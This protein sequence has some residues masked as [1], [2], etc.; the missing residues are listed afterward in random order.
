GNF[1]RTQLREVD[2]D[3]NLDGLVPNAEETHKFEEPPLRR[4]ARTFEFRELTRP[5]VYVID[6]IGSGKSSRALVRKGRLKPVVTT[7]TAGQNVAVVDEGNRPV[8]GATVWLGGKEYPC[9]GNGKAIVPFSSQPGRRPV[10]LT[11]GDYS[12]LDT[13]DHQPES[14][15]LTAGI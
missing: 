11:K 13:I 3:I 8:A 14:Y 4:V 9:D 12:C 1:Y 7:G 15:R 2:T 5:G 10:V 6:F